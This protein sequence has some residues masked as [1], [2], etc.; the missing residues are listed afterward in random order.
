MI[1]LFWAAI[2]TAQNLKVTGV[3]TSAEDSEPLIGVSVQVKENPSNG[4]AT[5]IDGQ[6]TITVA[7]GQTLRFSYVGCQT[8]ERKITAS[9]QLDIVM[10]PETNMLQEVVAIGYGTMKKSDLTGAVTSIAGDNLKKTPASSLAN[11]LQGQAAGVTVNSLSGRPGAQAEV[12]IR[13]VGTVN[14]ASPIYV[15]DGVITEE[16]A[17]FALDLLEVDK[18][19]LDHIDRN[20]LLT[21]IE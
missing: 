3:V 20:I 19:G 13:G 9:G 2:A 15:V 21:L 17:K 7:A 11:A 1:L 16:V 10:E 5:D 12:R 18:Y 8:V 6:Y 4:V 14:G